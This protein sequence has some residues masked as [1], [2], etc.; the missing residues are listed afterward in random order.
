VRTQA[1]LFIG[2]GGVIV[3]DIVRDSAD[4]FVYNFGELI[5]FLS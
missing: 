1:S 3:R 4:L 5:D 2:Y